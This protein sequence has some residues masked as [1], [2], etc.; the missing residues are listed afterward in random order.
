MQIKMIRAANKFIKI[1]KGGIKGFGCIAN[2]IANHF[3]L[4]RLKLI[5]HFFCRVLKE[6]ESLKPHAPVLFYSSCGFILI[7]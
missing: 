1:K 2:E 5:Y 6:I 4:T 3:F 7:V